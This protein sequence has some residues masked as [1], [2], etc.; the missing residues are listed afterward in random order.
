VHSDDCVQVRGD[1]GRH[2]A[3]PTYPS[4]RL[5]PDSLDAVFPGMA[6]TAPVAAY[7]EKQRVALELPDG[8]P[9]AFPVDALYVLGDPADAGDAVRI[10]PLGPAKTCQA[11]IR[12]SFRLDLDDRDGSAAHFER[13]AAL[14]KAAP[15]FLIEYPRDFSQSGALVEAIAQHLAGLPKRH[16]PA[17]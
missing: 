13:C 16:P 14:V 15:A 2:E 4:L 6:G 7:S 12:H 17:P 1:A 9:Q 5:Y 3:L 10:S 8:A 11:L